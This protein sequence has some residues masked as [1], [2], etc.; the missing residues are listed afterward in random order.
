MALKCWIA[1]CTIMVAEGWLLSAIGQLDGL[2]YVIVT[3]FALLVTVVLFRSTRFRWHLNLRRFRRPLPLGFALLSLV[4]SLGGII[5]AP[6]NYDTLSYRMPRLLAWLGAGHWTWISTTNQR[7][8]YSAA[9]FEWLSA[10]LLLISASD[11]LLFLLNLV[12]YLLLPGLIFSVYRLLGVGRRVAWT[13]MWILPTAFCFALQAASVGNDLIGAV[14][15]LASLHFSLKARPTRNVA[16]VWF[17]ILSIALATGVKGSNLPLLLPTLIALW[18][19]RQLLLRW[20]YR[21]IAVVALALLVSYLPTAILNDHFTGNWKGDPRNSETLQIGSPLA[22]VLGNALQLGAQNLQPPL[23]PSAGAL[24]QRLTALIPSGIRMFLK[25]EFPRFELQLGEL[26]QEEETGLGLPL[27]VL[28]GV[29]LFLRVFVDSGSEPRITVGSAV[30]R[31]VPWAAWA[32]VLVYM[33]MI[34][35]EAP[36][37]LLTPYYLLLL[38]PLLIERSRANWI[39]RRWW[40]WISLCAMGSTIFVLVLT[41]AR[42]LWPAERFL[43]TLESRWPENRQ[44]TRAAEVYSVYRQRNDVLG[45]LRDFLPRG[46]ASIAVIEDHNDLDYALWRPFGRRRVTYLV[47]ARPWKEETRGFTWVIGKTSLLEARYGNSL[48]QVQIAS[49]GQIIA[50]RLLISK[51][52][53]GPEEWFVMRLPE[54]A[55]PVAERTTESTHLGRGAFQDRNGRFPWA[56]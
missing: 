26:P 24:A 27:V 13:W 45:P 44:I 32:A 46:A 25:H 40:Q 28:C 34:G 30:V 36:A 9:N 51:V 5:N 4:A 6:N 12:P 7:M 14:F 15:V 49:G 8:N 35:S 37:R 41:P 18:P 53:V 48:E 17:A 21:S 19:V 31:L 43:T 54:V 55:E 29:C 50:I 56:S 16:N 22:G 20:P 42:P 1:L 23:L 39:R 38:P 11:R 3:G 47:G 33:A 2:A 52:R 10:P